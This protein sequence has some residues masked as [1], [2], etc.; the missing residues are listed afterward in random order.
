MKPALYM[1]V[2]TPDQSTYSQR[3]ELVEYSD[4]RGW[5]ADIP[6]IGGV[7]ERRARL[8]IFEDT[9]SGAKSDRP[10]LKALLTAVRRRAVDVV[11]VYSLDRLARST[12]H[13]V[14][15]MEEFKA[16]GVDL[17]SLKQNIDTTTP[18]GRFFF[19]VMAA[20]TELERETIAERVRAGMR[21]AAARGAKPGRPRVDAGSAARVVE[22][23]A[24]GRP[25][26]TICQETGV[27]MATVKRL[28]KANSGLNPGGQKGVS[29]DGLQ[30][31]DST[32]SPS[33]RIARVKN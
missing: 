31:V 27:S 7:P 3:H 12:K 8:Q 24:L 28:L 30:A 32:M 16:A 33:G 13:L 29:P 19:T 2:S 26:A 5:I 11:V 15:L 21:A 4:R 20:L 14:E 17:I 1:R 22:L 9:I 10:G 25:L 18:M 23:R 6:G